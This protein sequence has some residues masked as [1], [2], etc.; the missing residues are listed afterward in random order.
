MSSLSEFHSGGGSVIKGW[1]LRDNLRSDSSPTRALTP[2]WFDFQ[3]CH[4]MTRLVTFVVHKG[5]ALW[6]LAWHQSQ[7]PMAYAPIG[8]VFRE[9]LS[10]TCRYAQKVSFMI[11]NLTVIVLKGVFTSEI[12]FHTPVE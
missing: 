4:H 7:L 12:L 11:D 5:A 1:C 2:V 10:T 9:C 6:E 8:G 3:L